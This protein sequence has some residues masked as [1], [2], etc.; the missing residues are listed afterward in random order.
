MLGSEHIRESMASYGTLWCLS[1]SW[2]F[3][4]GAIFALLS[5]FIEFQKP[6]LK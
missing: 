3:F 4:I 2:L 6:N 1:S 5:R